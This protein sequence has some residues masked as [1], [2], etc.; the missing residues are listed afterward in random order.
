MIKFKQKVWFLA[1][2][3]FNRKKV[4]PHAGLRYASIHYSSHSAHFTLTLSVWYIY[5]MFEIYIHKH[6]HSEYIYTSF[7]M[8][9]V[10]KGYF[11]F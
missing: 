10:H 11:P 3:K 2:Y 7:D 9:S 1:Y 6:T 5:I 4:L 8:Y